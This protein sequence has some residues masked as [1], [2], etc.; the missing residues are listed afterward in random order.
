MAADK[1]LSWVGVTTSTVGTGDYACG[2]VLSGSPAGPW[3]SFSAAY[4]DTDTFP[5]VCFDATRFERGR[6]RFNAGPN[7]VTR[8]LIIENHL[9]TLSPITWPGGGGTRNLFV[10]SGSGAVARSALGLGSAAVLDAGV[11]ANQVV[12][13]DGSAKIPTGTDISQAINVPTHNHTA[14]YFPSLS[15]GSN[16]TIVR[17]SGAGT[18][19]A[20][21][22]SDSPATLQVLFAKGSDGNIYGRGWFVPFTGAA[23]GN[24]YYLGTAGAI[25]TT[26]SNGV[27]DTPDGTHT[28]VVVGF[29][30]AANVLYFDPTRPVGGL[31]SAGATLK[32]EHGDL[33]V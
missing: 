9:G 29:G 8:V 28:L 25:S 21:A 27:N 14:L 16:S 12:A 6:G 1:A 5:Y 7:T 11:S 3:R 17:P 13:L 15:G 26:F 23:Y 20:A 2:A 24:R 19:T 4:S 32:L 31:L 22:L 33:K 30:V 10:D 18:V